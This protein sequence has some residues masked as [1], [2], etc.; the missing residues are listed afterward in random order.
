MP[1]G[2]TDNCGECVYFKGKNGFSG[3]QSI[4]D[5]RLPHCSL[6]RIIIS[7]D[8][9]WTYCRNCIHGDRHQM[10]QPSGPVCLDSGEYPYRRKTW[11]TDDQQRLLMKEHETLAGFLKGNLELANPALGD[12]FCYTSLP[13]CVIDAV[14]SIGAHYSST[15]K[16]IARCKAEFFNDREE[17]GP[18]ED[19][20]APSMPSFTITQ[21]LDLYERNGIEFMAENVFKSKQRTST[22]NGILKAE[23]VMLFSRALLDFGVDTSEDVWKIIGNT[24]FEAAI[25]SIPGQGSGIS[26]AY[27]YILAGAKDYVKPDRMIQRLLGSILDRKVAVKECQPLI[28]GASLLLEKEYPSI[29]PC[30]IDH[31]MWK[32]QSGREKTS[33]AND[34][35]RA[36]LNQNC[37]AMDS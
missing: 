34:D 11:I 6:R 31:L 25:K 5:L 35:L 22:R 33:M 20:K 7:S 27:F 23:A 26:L 30:V 3:D 14:F 2:G 12:E 24:E 36:S 1:N 32:F 4:E 16:V 17:K 10:D 28:F 29:R 19:T 15:E 37:V 13:L 8:P 21:L 9:F 18:F